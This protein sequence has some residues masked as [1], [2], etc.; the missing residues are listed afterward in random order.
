MSAL[1]L[2]MNPAGKVVVHRT[3][4]SWLAKLQQ[5]EAEWAA[6]MHSSVLV[7]VVLLAGGAVAALWAP[8]LLRS[9]GRTVTRYMSFRQVASPPQA[10][11]QRRTRL[12][13]RPEAASATR[14]P[15]G[16]TLAD[17]MQRRESRIRRATALAFAVFVLI[18]AA[19]FM[20]HERVSALDYA[21]MLFPL[22]VL[23]AGPAGV[24]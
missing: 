14:E 17:A 20:L 15:G 8:W 22:I 21:N 24:I 16:G 6:V 12:L 10:W 2:Y 18:G 4:F 23:A 3:G 9:Y 19:V 1:S 7:L 5:A 11:W 13:H